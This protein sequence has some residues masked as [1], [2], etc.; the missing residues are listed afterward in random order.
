[1]EVFCCSKLFFTM[2]GNGLILGCFAVKSV[3]SAT[4][5]RHRIY[6]LIGVAYSRVFSACLNVDVLMGVYVPLW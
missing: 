5:V 4:F 2:V 1:M 6:K 3:S